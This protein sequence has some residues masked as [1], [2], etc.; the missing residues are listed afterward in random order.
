ML[1][2]CA[3]MIEVLEHYEEFV[4]SNRYRAALCAHPMKADGLEE[5]LNQTL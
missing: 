3:L 4:K 2:A 1:L 5:S